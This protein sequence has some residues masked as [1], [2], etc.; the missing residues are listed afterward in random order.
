M[1]VSNFAPGVSIYFVYAIFTVKV[2]VIFDY[3]ATQPDELTIKV[4]DVISD[5]RKQPGGW[6]E[7]VLNG[8]KGVFP[9]NFVEVCTIYTVCLLTNSEPKADYSLHMITLKELTCKIS[10]F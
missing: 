1:L 3:D 8:R 2:K 9:D 5:V 4:G 10:F 7:G 6:W